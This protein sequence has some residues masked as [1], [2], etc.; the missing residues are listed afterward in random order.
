M[1]VTKGDTRGDRKGPSLS[2][3]RSPSGVLQVGLLVLAFVSGFVIHQQGWHSPLAT[4]VVSFVRRPAFTATALLHRSDLPALYV[5][6][7]FGDY[8]RLLDKRSQALHLGA[9]VASAQD[10]VPASISHDDVGVAI[11]MRLLEGPV[12]SLEDEAWPFE[13]VVQDNGT[14]LGLRHF[15][16]TPADTTVLSTWGYLE[17]LRRADL[18][19][20]RYHLPLSAPIVSRGQ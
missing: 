13:V 12:E 1:R 6:M 3:L 4:F 11:Q 9:N 18:L 17:T 14:L 10:Y 8:Q 5:D 2:T 15:T 7:R 19:S 16:L 20:S